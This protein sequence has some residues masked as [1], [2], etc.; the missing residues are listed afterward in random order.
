MNDKNKCYFDNGE[1]CSALKSMDCEKCSFRK[2]RTEY[3]E[4]QKKSKERLERIGRGDV[5]DG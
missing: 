4:A 3:F 2:T 5:D 1:E